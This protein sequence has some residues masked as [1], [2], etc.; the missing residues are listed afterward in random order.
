MLVIVTTF[1]GCIGNLD[2]F[3]SF[4]TALSMVGNV[5]PAFGKLDPTCNYGWLPAFVKW[6]YTFAMIAG[7]LEL[8]TFVIFFMPAYW[9]K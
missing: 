6:W 5:G 4:T 3:T 1:V 8:Y 2:L 9:K 7:R